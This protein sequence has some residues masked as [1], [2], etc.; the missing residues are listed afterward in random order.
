[1]QV[2]FSEYTV[3]KK[4]RGMDIIISR[5]V[6]IVELPTGKDFYEQYPFFVTPA[7]G[8]VPYGLFSTSPG[9]LPAPAVV[10]P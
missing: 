8:T 7:P 4:Y 9:Y 10:I 5:I 3:G 1:M 2:I 6:P